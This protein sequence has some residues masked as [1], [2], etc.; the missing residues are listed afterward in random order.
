MRPVQFS[1]LFVQSLVS[2]HATRAIYRS[3]GPQRRDRSCDAAVFLGHVIL[4]GFHF[5]SSWD[6]SLCLVVRHTFVWLL[7]ALGRTGYGS[8]SK[9]L[10]VSVCQ[11]LLQI[12]FL[13]WFVVD[14][15]LIRMLHE[16]KP[17]KC[18]NAS[19]AHW[20]ITP[21]VRIYNPHNQ[22]LTV[23]VK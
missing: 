11:R 5:G 13:R 19:K 14:M 16:K 22:Y 12:Y 8:N 7:A 4:N 10:V 20:L 15:N 21:F 1:K 18:C 3:F 9:L 2:A 23:N 6:S 17:L